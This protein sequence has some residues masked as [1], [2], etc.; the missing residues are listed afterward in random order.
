MERCPECGME[1]AKMKE[2]ILAMQHARK[3]AAEQKKSGGTAAAPLPAARKIV[4]V[5]QARMESAEER[6]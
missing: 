3:R 6:A 5:G 4:P 2:Y 1:V